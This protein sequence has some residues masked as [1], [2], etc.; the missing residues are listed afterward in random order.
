M[1]SALPDSELQFMLGTH[2][3]LEVAVGKLLDLPESQ[4]PFFQSISDN[5][6][7][8]TENR[9]EQ[10]SDPRGGRGRAPG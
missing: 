7:G 4:L 5:R 8:L 10:L 2:R 3:T 1:Q 9:A 6:I